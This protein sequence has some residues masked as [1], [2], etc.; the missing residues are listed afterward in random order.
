MAEEKV[1]RVKQLTRWQRIGVASLFVAG[2]FVL[3]GA[4]FI[5]SGLYNIGATRE[6]WSVTN[7]I[8]TILRDRSVA[9]AAGG[10]EVPD[11]DDAD[12]YELGE[13]HFLGTCTSCHG[14]PGDPLNPLYAHMLPQP[15]DLTGA[16]EHYDARE[17]FWIVNHGLKY[18]GMPSWPAPHRPDEV[19]TVVSYLERLNRIGPENVGAEDNVLERAQSLDTCRR[20]HGGAGE[21]P[22]SD[23]VPRL[24][25]MSEHY[26]RRALEEYRDGQ[27]ASGVMGPIAFDMS[28][29]VIAGS[30]ASYAALPPP[31]GRVNPDADLT[32]GRRIAEEGIAGQDVPACRS[33]HGGGNPQVPRLAGQSERYMSTQLKL[34]QHAEYRDASPEGRLM[35]IIGGRLTEDQGQAV[36]AYYATLDAEPGR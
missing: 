25:G 30:A 16:F 7:F 5:L 2:A 32:L 17:V 33:C 12:L 26:L 23:L 34:W 22:V 1:V 4:A 10:I 31:Q 19:W 18:T 20:C 27:R 24:N 8:I 35:S 15:P 21:G 28:D 29:E 6:H 36:S 13:Q 14:T 3:T 11:L 9:V